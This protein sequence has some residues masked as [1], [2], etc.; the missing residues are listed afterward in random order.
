MHHILFNENHY[1]HGKTTQTR[2]PQKNKGLRMK[3]STVPSIHD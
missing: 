3:V 1:F 2:F